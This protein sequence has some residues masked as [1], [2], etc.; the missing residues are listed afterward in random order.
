MTNMTVIGGSSRPT[1]SAAMKLEELASGQ[2]LSGIE[3]TEVVSVLALV[4]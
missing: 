2:N 1:G 3:P 4:A